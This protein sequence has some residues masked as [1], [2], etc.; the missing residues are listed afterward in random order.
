[1]PLR[2]AAEIEALKQKLPLLPLHK[3]RVKELQ[4]AAFGLVGIRGKLKSVVVE[5]IRKYLA[6]APV[7]D[8]L[9]QQ[10]WR[11]LLDHRCLAEFTGTA[12]APDPPPG[13]VAPGTAGPWM[14][15]TGF[16]ASALVGANAGAYS[17]AS[18]TALGANLGVPGPSTS[19]SPAIGAAS[20]FLISLRRSNPLV[21]TGPGIYT[22]RSHMPPPPVPHALSG[23][24]PSS[25]ALASFGLSAPPT[26]AAAA[27]APKPAAL[28][29]AALRNAALACVPPSRVVG[30]FAFGPVRAVNDSRFHIASAAP[31]YDALGRSCKHLLVVTALDPVSLGPLLRV[32]DGARIFLDGRAVRIPSSRVCAWDVSRI[33]L[34][35]R[36][37]PSVELV[38]AFNE[39]AAVVAAAVVEARS[40]LEDAAPMRA[41]RFGVAH[42]AA[43][44]LAMRSALRGSMPMPAIAPAGSG[45][46]LSSAETVRQAIASTGV[47]RGPTLWAALSLKEMIRASKTEERRRLRKQPDAS[48]VSHATAAAGVGAD[49]GAGAGAA[50]GTGA[51]GAGAHAQ[52]GTNGIASTAAGAAAGAAGAAGAAAAGSN[53]EASDS[54]SDDDVMGTADEAV[55]VADPFRLNAI[56]VPVR[57]SDCKHLSVF[58]AKTFEA[59]SAHSSSPQARSCPFCKQPLRLEDLRVDSALA[60]V[61]A[62]VR[63]GATSGVIEDTVAAAF[64]QPGAV[65]P[66]LAA[67]ELHTLLQAG[68]GVSSW[69]NA[70]DG[71]AVD[72]SRVHSVRLGAD[73][74]W[75]AVGLDGKDLAPMA[76]K[77]PRSQSETSAE[78]GG[79]GSAKR[80]RGE[81]AG[82]FG[83]KLDDEDDDDEDDEEEELR[84]L[85]DELAGRSSG[86]EPVTPAA[87]TPSA[88]NDEEE[89]VI[90]LT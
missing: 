15:S 3:L 17:A 37:C 57:G 74:S 32:P 70:E 60:A 77:R 53:D 64:H 55:R 48:A 21:R 10:M 12:P 27:M 31:S 29:G 5:S 13:R 86:P 81:S 83:A 11:L 89:D 46:S 52:P 67:P 69:L 38:V 75:Q 71:V 85:V 49:V 34:R 7:E 80:P 72:K 30:K 62:A 65:G 14:A 35:G 6:A 4:A 40:Q 47:L 2:S 73:G 41:L 23:A 84:R 24:V 26:F 39:P 87:P 28:S 22:P 33:T 88:R 9:A 1:M 63:G 18:S 66:S 59:L 68:S 44:V 51:A 78:G 42:P 61:L 82:A 43:A 45:A 56:G 79:A 76:Q 16:P 58:D 90:D 19:V 54:D 50:A 36:R 8:G 25:T 20:S